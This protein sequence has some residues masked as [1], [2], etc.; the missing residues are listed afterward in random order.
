MELSKKE[1]KKAPLLIRSASECQLR[2]KEFYEMCDDEDEIA[3]FCK[4][5]EQNILDNMHIRNLSSQYNSKNN[6]HN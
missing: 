4:F 6:V 2:D 3:M 1:E 5:A